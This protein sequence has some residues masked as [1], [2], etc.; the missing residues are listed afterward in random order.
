MDE[1]PFWNGLGI[2]GVQAE[3]MKAESSDS[4]IDGS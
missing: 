1:N 3:G 2:R 4:K